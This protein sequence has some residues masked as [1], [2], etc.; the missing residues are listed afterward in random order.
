MKKSV[1]M[2]IVKA[3]YNRSTKT[4]LGV[5]FILAAFGA[6]YLSLISSLQ[7]NAAYYAALPI[8]VAVTVATAL[9]ADKKQAKYYV[10]GVVA[11][12]TGLAVSVGFDFFKNGLLGFFNA[13]V[14]TMN[15]TRHA[16]YE[17]L[18][19]DESFGAAFLFASVIA[20]WF[21]EFSLFAI[22]KAYVYICVSAPVVLALIFMGMTPQYFVVVLLV[23]VYVCLMAIHNGFT[24]KALCC[25][26]VC[27]AVVT[28]VT[29]P[30]YFYTGSKAV[31]DF[32]DSITEA[33]EDMAYGKSMPSGK[34]SDSS[35]MRSSSEVRLKI[36]LSG[37]T[38]KL[39]LRGFV[40][41]DLDGSE[42]S[43]TDKNAYV[44]NGYQ[45]LIDYIAKGGLPTTQYAAYSDLCKR[46]NKY[47]IT[48][49]NVSA[50]RRY[51][52]VP[53]TLSEYTVGKAY[54]DMGL[55]GSITS[56]KKYSYTVFAPD[57][58]GERVTQASWILSDADRSAAMSEYIKLEG[59]YRAF[60][61]DT[62]ADLDAD[63]KATVQSVIGDFK[64]DSVNTATQFIRSYF[65]DS[66]TYSDECDGIGQ[67][68]ATDFFG[69][70]INRANAAYFASAATCMFRALGF[71]ARY[72]EGY[73]VYFL[74][75][76]QI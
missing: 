3:V 60:V 63:T 47:D 1:K 76:I 15:A 33:F 61:Y 2:T 22:K 40:G 70:K 11:V 56:P 75:L 41:S 21:A 26:L 28:V 32:G 69:G 16:G 13:A 38:S 52:Y 14:R 18:V 12:F 45:G 50:D 43:S 58:S 24:V 57:E 29:F 30:C 49:E 10:L 27:I 54:Y 53:Y 72:A 44:E 42:W 74:S 19:A 51:I 6:L 8:G 39:Y 9:L 31:D 34:L 5:V 4:A 66:F 65:L 37:L 48:V 20:A 64:T 73:T 46:N 25:Y 35:G 59:Q 68:F 17:L 23:V 36:T 71:A 55:R 62:Y 7:F 67:S